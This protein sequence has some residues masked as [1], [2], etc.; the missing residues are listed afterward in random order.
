[1]MWL[2]WW[3]G[4]YTDPKFRSVAAKAG[5]SLP[6]VMAV[7]AAVLEHASDCDSDNDSERGRLDGFDAETIDVHYGL[8]AG[9][10][11]AI[12]EAME[13]KG[14][15]RE[16]EVVNW[17][18]RQPKRDD[19]SAERVRRYRDRKRNATDCNAGV[20]HGNAGVT[21]LV[22]HGNAPDRDTDRET[23][24]N[25]PPNAHTGAHTHA[26]A[27]EGAGARERPTEFAQ[28]VERARVLWSDQAARFP[29]ELDQAWTRNGTLRAWWEE[30]PTSAFAE[31]LEEYATAD[32]PHTVNHWLKWVRTAAR[33]V[34]AATGPNGATPAKLPPSKSAQRLA[35]LEAS[36]K[37]AKQRR[38]AE[39]A[40]ASKGVTSGSE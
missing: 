36:A 37:R 13:T 26:H 31:G 12:V 19:D 21:A 29:V 1:M 15:I 27:R 2:R 16:G 3:H 40:S 24:K 25:P 38:L 20:T 39:E 32:P 10:C 28:I 22:T 33:R 14:L 4:T 5:A 11:Q 18:K 30:L 23:E 35:E 8:E 9:R 7:W 17:S 6:E 34:G